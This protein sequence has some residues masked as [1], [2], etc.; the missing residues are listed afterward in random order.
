MQVLKSSKTRD[1]R[2]CGCPQQ[3]GLVQS[4]NIRFKDGDIGVEGHGMVLGSKENPNSRL[5]HRRA[6]ACG[7]HGSAE[8]HQSA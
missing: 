6:C 3:A 8:G 4:G 7:S 2:F 1:L 5:W